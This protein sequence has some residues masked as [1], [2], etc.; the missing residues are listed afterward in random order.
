MGTGAR[1]QEAGQWALAILSQGSCRGG[2]G[3]DG[4]CGASQGTVTGAPV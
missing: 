3:L 2:V 4:I 1:L